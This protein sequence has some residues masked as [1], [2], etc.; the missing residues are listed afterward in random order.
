MSK[1]VDY[2]FTP[3]SPFTYM[4]H[5]RFVAIA[6]RHG[7]SINVKPVDLGKVFAVSG[8]LP[9]KQRAAQ[10]QAYRLFELKRWSRLLGL[11]LNLQ[12]K[13]FPVPADLASKWILAALEQGPDAGL[14]LA[15]AFMRAVWAE[16]RNVSDADTLA[17]I[18]REQGFDAAALGD[19]AA[20]E[21]IGSRYEA[22]TQEAIDAQVFGAPTFIYRDEPFWGQDRLDFLDRS[23]AK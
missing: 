21:A 22:L 7:A 12:P 9:L 4:G 2:F 11:P 3:V 23:L 16:D 18:A 10:R 19:R 1:S 8:G 17:S 13:F 20:A 6:A 15:G 14:K 5:D